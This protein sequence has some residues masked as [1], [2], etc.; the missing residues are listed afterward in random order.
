MKKIVAVL[1]L[2]LC[3]CVLF[4]ACGKESTTGDITPS[5][6]DDIN[7]PTADDVTPDEP[8][9]PE[10]PV[11]PG[12]PTEPDKPTEPEN[13]VEP[14]QPNEPEQ[15]ENND[16][17][18]PTFNPEEYED[19]E[20]WQIAYLE[21]MVED[22]NEYGSYFRSTFALVFVDSDNIPELYISGPDSASGTRLCSYKDGLV[23]KQHCGTEYI[24]ASG[25]V[26]NYMG[27]MG[28]Y[29]TDVF[30]LTEDGFLSIFNGREEHLP[31]QTLAD[32]GERITK[33]SHE[34]FI[35]KTPVTEEEF[36]D[37]IAKVFD[38]NISIRFSD[39]TTLYKYSTMQ[40]AIINWDYSILP[41]EAPVLPEPP[42]PTTPPA[43][44]AEPETPTEPEY[45]DISNDPVV[46]AGGIPQI[47]YDAIEEGEWEKAYAMLYSIKTP[48]KKQ[49]EL[50][51][52]FVFLP[53]ET[54]SGRMRKYLHIYEF[55]DEGN[56]YSDSYYTIN[57]QVDKYYY[58]K[59]G[60]LKTVT[61]YKDQDL[62]QD[63]TYFYHG[64]GTLSLKLYETSWGDQKITTY[65]YDENGNLVYSESPSEKVTYDKNGNILSLE[66]SYEKL[67]YTYDEK[68][69]LI[70]EQ[71]QD[72]TDRGDHRLY[73][74]TYDN[75]GRVLTKQTDMRKYT[76]TYDQKGNLLTYTSCYPSGKADFQTTF[77]YDEK[78][79]RI[80]TKT[81]YGDGSTKIT[82]YE[83]DE[84]GNMLS[85]TIQQSGKTT[86]TEYTYDE[87]GNVLTYKK[88]SESN[89]YSYT[90]E[91]H[92]FPNAVP[93]H[94]ETYENYIAE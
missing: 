60:T 14:E 53:K 52:H 19:L 82:T 81:L 86:K 92:Y 13:P 58:N 93:S 94:P 65:K 76:Y 56:I 73:S 89:V 69:N 62:W 83:R 11:E 28:N 9:E 25:L 72:L 17:L 54:F 18:Y 24:P 67:T 21:Y 1:S 32:N 27:H 48:S 38:N 34:Y 16:A 91:L 36:N 33:S 80:E 3:L 71:L 45:P 50:M 63:F 5:T 68:G 55:D 12:K 75:E 41:P 10:K 43:K 39:N 7:N 29:R 79:H 20:P 8:A 88:S 37:A 15:P 59:D 2:V 22:A 31:Y 26:Y 85:E 44:P 4:S 47:V 84:K 51:S 35:D 87:Y 74:Y 57:R 66:R 30:L 77:F 64:N 23:V 90:Y 49:K 78:E 42:T 61:F 70:T 46:L 6:N 40:E